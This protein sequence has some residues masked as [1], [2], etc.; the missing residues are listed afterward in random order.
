MRWYRSDL[1]LEL[2]IGLVLSGIVLVALTP[3]TPLGTFERWTLGWIV[4]CCVAATVIVYRAIRR[5]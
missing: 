2:L 1:L 4:A 3:L 5:I